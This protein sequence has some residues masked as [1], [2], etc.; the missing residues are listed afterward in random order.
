MEEFEA[1]HIDGSLNFPLKLPPGEVT[2]RYI[3]ADP[4]G[5]VTGPLIEGGD[6]TTQPDLKSL[7][8][9]YTKHASVTQ[10]VFYC[11]DDQIRS[12]ALAFWYKAKHDQPNTQVMVLFGGLQGW[13]YVSS[14]QHARLAV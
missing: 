5:G 8:L 6:K 10:V 13:L 12:L 9:H 2:W 7:V 1:G 4:N 14:S 11:S 3:G